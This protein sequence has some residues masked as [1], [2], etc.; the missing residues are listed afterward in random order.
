[1][2]GTFWT[3]IKQYRNLGALTL[4]ELEKGVMERI[5]TR[6]EC[7]VRDVHS[8]FNGRLAYTTLMT[9][10]DRLH[11]KG[12]LHREKQGKAFLYRPALSRDDLDRKVAQELIGV[13]V[14][15]DR[16]KSLPILSC[17]VDAISAEDEELLSAL[18]QEI[19]K[20]RA[21]MKQVTE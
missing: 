6:G 1:M 8:D 13:M 15:E 9:T 14:Q 19:Q 20:R 5:W 3:K 10:V 4:G 16:A 21:A 18:E 2:L 17:F 7:T 11:K 12:M